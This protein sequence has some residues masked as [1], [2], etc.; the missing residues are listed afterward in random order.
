MLRLLNVL[1]LVAFPS[2][3]EQGHTAERKKEK[4]HLKCFNDIL[5][6]VLQLL[7]ISLARSSINKNLRAYY[8]YAM[9]HGIC[10]WKELGTLALPL[11]SPV[12]SA[13]SIKISRFLF[14][15]SLSS[16]FAYFQCVFPLTSPLHNLI[17]IVN[18]SKLM[19]MRCSRSKTAFASWQQNP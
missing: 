18:H 13:G 8:Y 12:L 5:F 19:S 17:T 3:N 16:P 2:Q 4:S 9:T 14:T 7:G 11:G 15:R 6:N 1:F 10:I